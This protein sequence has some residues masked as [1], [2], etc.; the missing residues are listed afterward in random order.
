MK[1]AEPSAV[2]RKA[3]S[4]PNALELI[5]RMVTA[6]MAKTTANGMSVGMNRRMTSSTPAP[7]TAETWATHACVNQW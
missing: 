5:R 2:A 1:L 6:Q 4:T 7:D 3:A